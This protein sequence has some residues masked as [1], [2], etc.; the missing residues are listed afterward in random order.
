MAWEP[1]IDVANDSSTDGMVR[2]LYD[3]TRDRK[4][5]QVSDLIRLNSAT[6]SVA[7]LLHDLN[8]AI[9]RAARGLT[10]REQEI[11]ALVVASFNGCV[12]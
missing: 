7:G 11:A 12:H 6:P 9:H 10:V 3:R 1:W 8:I 2:E 5:G 4:T